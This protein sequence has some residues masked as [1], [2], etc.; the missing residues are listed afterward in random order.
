MAEHCAECNKPDIKGQMYD[1]TY[2]RCLEQSD[3]EKVESTCQ[4]LEEW[5]VTGTGYYYSTGSYCLMCSEFQFGRVKNSMEMGS[6]D[7]GTTI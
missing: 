5:G 7:G 3:S 1:S 4:G 6:S 2:M